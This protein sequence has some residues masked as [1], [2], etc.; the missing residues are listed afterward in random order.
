MSQDERGPSLR[1]E[2]KRKEK[3]E[4]FLSNFSIVL[5]D[6]REKKIYAKFFNF[7]FGLV[8]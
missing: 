2:E 4:F 8:I 7:I 3:N 6:G 1:K 5:F